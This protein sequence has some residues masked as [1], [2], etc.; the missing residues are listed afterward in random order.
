MSIAFVLGNG[1]S[2]LPYD[3]NI[4]RKYGTIIGCNSAYMDIDPD[5]LVS[6][7]LPMIQTILESKQYKELYIPKNIY[8][9][10]FLCDTRLKYYDHQCPGI[11]DSGNFALMIASI[12]NHSI[13]YMLGFDYVSMNEFTNNVYAG[14]HLYKQKHQKHV[15]PESEMNWYNKLAIVLARYPNA[16]VR[17]NTN[18]YVPPTSWVNFKNIEIVDF[19]NKFPH[20]YDT[21]MEVGPGFTMEQLIELKRKKVSDHFDR[22]NNAPT[23]YV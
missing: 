22:M 9:Q 10:H 5:I 17:V 14:Q 21:D 18:K 16:F 20:S 23:I 3:I 19:L 4:L 7:D 2:R 13:I 12:T 6:V 8:E 15:L 11:V 1:R